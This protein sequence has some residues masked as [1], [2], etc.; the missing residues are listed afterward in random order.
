MN[1]LKQ[2]W[3]FLKSLGTM[4]LLAA[5]ASLI[6]AASAGFLT[7]NALGITSQEPVKTVTINAGEGATGPTGPAGPTGPKG[8]TGDQG[9]KGDTGPAGPPGGVTCPTGFSDGI[10]VINHPG[11]QVSIFTCLKD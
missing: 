4:T 8:D 9:P 5:G 2:F 1:M 11:G 3:G 6:L 10:L 7:A